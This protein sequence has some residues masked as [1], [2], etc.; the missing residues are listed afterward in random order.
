MQIAKFS[1]ASMF[2]HDCGI[3]AMLGDSPTPPCSIPASGPQAIEGT[4]FFHGAACALDSGDALYSAPAD[5]LASRI[6]CAFD[7]AFRGLPQAPVLTEGFGL[8]RRCA[9]RRAMRY[10]LRRA[11]AAVPM[12]YGFWM[13]AADIE[14]AAE[15]ENLIRNGL[16]NAGSSQYLP[17]VWI[18]TNSQGILI[19][20]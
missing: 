19:C 12:S 16:E 5:V 14:E 3:V 15:I 2:G 20:L 9:T 18:S 7:H 17:E 1:Q 6:T 10:A 11:P 13:P 4:E 8:P